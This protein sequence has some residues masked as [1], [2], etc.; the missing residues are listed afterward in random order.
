MLCDTI[1][2]TC[3]TKSKGHRRQTHGTHTVSEGERR[4][5]D[6]RSNREW[7]VHTDTRLL[8]RDIQ[9]PDSNQYTKH[10]SQT[11]TVYGGGPLRGT[12]LARILLDQGRLAVV[13]LTIAC[14]G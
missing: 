6:R 11:Y 1:L 7:Q 10:P 14:G 2:R 12:G 3:A 5:V 8:I 13:A 9:V 4:R